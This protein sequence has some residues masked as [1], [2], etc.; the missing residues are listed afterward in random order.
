MIHKTA[1][2]DCLYDTALIYSNNCDASKFLARVVE[3]SLIRFI[4]VQKI[5]WILFTIPESFI[6][7]IHSD[8]GDCL[9]S[10][11][12]W[13][14]N[15]SFYFLNLLRTIALILCSSTAT[16]ID[17]IRYHNSAMKTYLEDKNWSYDRDGPELLKET[18]I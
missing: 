9:N 8:F 14:T 12:E 18:T 5:V 13:R 6:D 10:L 17:S 11:P 15:D 16:F 3:H 4:L 2:I 1:W 7:S